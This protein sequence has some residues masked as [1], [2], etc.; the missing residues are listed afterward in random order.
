MTERAQESTE[1][2][3]STLERAARLWQTSTLA[4]IGVVL[5]MFLTA[6]QPGGVQESIT[7]RGLTIVNKEGQPICTIGSTDTDS[8]VLVLTRADG[9][10]SLSI[11]ADS[12]KRIGGSITINT[13]HG[14]TAASLGTT[15]M[16][17]QLWLGDERGLRLQATCAPVGDFAGGSIAVYDT[18]ERLAAIMAATRNE[19]LELR[20]S[21][22]LL[23]EGQ[24]ALQL[25]S[26]ADGAFVVGYNSKHR[27]VYHL[28][29]GESGEGF[30]QLYNG[31]KEH[32]PHETI[33]QAP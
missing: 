33:W 4:L 18:Q 28:G 2:R 21:L 8:G 22:A 20:G 19:Q 26:D 13:L 1:E 23:H 14:K 3:L 25:G 31:T 11:E 5:V 32:P 7:A 6:Q 29:A 12:K 27:E 30:M 15:L 24:R 16:G 9:R 17:G 10:P